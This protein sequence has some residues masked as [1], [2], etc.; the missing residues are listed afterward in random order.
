VSNYQSTLFSREEIAAWT[1]AFHFAKPTGFGF[2]AGQAIDIVL[3]DPAGADDGNTRHTFS[4][5]T[6]PFED[7]LTIATRMRDTPFKR[8]LKDLPDGSPIGIEGPSG[9]L[10]L[11]SKPERAAIMIAGGIGITPFVS[12][13][14]QAAIDPSPRRLVLLYSNHRP[15]DTAFLAELQAMERSNPNFRLLATMT[16]MDESSQ[17]WQ[18]ATEGIDEKLLRRIAAELAAPIYYLAGPPAMVAA[19]R[20]TLNEAGVDDDDLRSEEFYGY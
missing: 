11:H 7:K 18:G 14:R 16:R 17:G 5:V 3:S 20:Q 6:A 9:S 2:K 13:L 4:I 15:E 10:V 19:M 12:I 1:M 8:R